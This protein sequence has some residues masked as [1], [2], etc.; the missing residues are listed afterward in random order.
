MI[1]VFAGANDDGFPTKGA[2]R[3]RERGAR[4]GV[5]SIDRSDFLHSDIMKGTSGLYTTRI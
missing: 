2:L 3:N 5:R 4:M 1:S